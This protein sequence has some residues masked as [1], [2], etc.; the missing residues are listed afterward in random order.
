MQKYAVTQQDSTRIECHHVQRLEQL[1]YTVTLTSKEAAQ[2]I[3][4]RCNGL[5]SEG[6]EL[7]LPP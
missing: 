6:V 2:R 4:Q 3:P 1:G 7:K 5:F